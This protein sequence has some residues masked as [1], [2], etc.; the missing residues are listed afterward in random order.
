MSQAV[1][2]ICP[3]F[4]G[5]NGHSGAP[6]LSVNGP[7]LDNAHSH[8]RNNPFATFGKTTEMVRPGPSNTFVLLDEDSYSL[9]DA[10]FAVGMVRA[11]WIDWPATYH[12]MACGFAFGDGHSEI[13]KWRDGRTRVINGNVSRLSVPRSVDWAWISDHTSARVR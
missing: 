13:H 3:G 6:T 11:E 10:G 12:G 2:T 7:W 8:T 9:N 5:G 1:G 4:N